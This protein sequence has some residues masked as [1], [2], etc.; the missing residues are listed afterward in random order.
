MSSG[1]RS[2]LSLSKLSAQF[3]DTR[4]FYEILIDT[5]TDRN[6]RAATLTVVSLLEGALQKFL[7]TK[8]T[9]PEKEGPSDLFGSGAPLRDF[10]SKIKMGFALGL[11]G[12]QTKADLDAIREVRNAFAHTME[13]IDFDTPEV[14]NVCNRIVIL[15]LSDPLGEMK[16]AP[17]RLRFLTT[18]TC[19]ATEFHI[20]SAPKL[21][22]FG[23]ALSGMDDTFWVSRFGQLMTS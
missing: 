5:I 20:L 17:V 11:Y 7:I 19:F 13:P 6:A 15:D 23:L 21:H 3:P 12:P 8:L 22:S 10:S 18:A 2:F 16:D 4:A 9:I 14:V 1:P